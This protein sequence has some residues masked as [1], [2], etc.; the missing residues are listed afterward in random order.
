MIESI[1]TK[2]GDVSFRYEE[3]ESLLSKPDITS[4][5]EEFIKLS[6]EYADLSPVVNAFNAFK[7]AEGDMNEAKVLM[8]DSDPEIKQMAEIEFEKL[9]QNIDDLEMNLNGYYF[10]KILMI[11]KMFFLK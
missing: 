10:P 5:Q 11:Q 1:L 8:K 9:K 6:K 2:L 7:K 4:N 3:I